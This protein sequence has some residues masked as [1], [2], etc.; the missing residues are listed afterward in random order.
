[1]Q[2]KVISKPMEPPFVEI[3]LNH[4]Y[5]WHVFYPFMTEAFYNCL[6][7]AYM[8]QQKNVKVLRDEYET[9]IDKYFETLKN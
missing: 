9:M 7:E 4:Y 1:M 6:E 5:R 8:R 2:I 3:K